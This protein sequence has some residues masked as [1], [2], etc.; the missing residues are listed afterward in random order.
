MQ[1]PQDTDEFDFDRWADLA[2]SDPQAFEIK[3]TNA[4]E[5]IINKASPRTRHKLRQIQW[6]IDTIRKTSATPL[7]ASVRIQEM[8]WQ[9]MLGED[10]LLACL[11]RLPAL[12]KQ[13]GQTARILDF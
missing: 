5:A 8:M 11:Q 6:K 13:P 7:A 12:E 2:L 4:V 3:R 10:G 9:S 1:A